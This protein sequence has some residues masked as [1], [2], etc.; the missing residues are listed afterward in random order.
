[1][2]DEYWN[3]FYEFEQQTIYHG[4][5][6]ILIFKFSFFFSFFVI[7]TIYLV[8][9]VL[10]MKYKREATGK[11]LIPNVEF[12]SSLPGLV[13]VSKKCIKV[14]MFRGSTPSSELRKS[15]MTPSF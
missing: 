11:E 10:F 12:W 6:E 5:I 1:M 7:A 3:I 14:Y 13:K 4:H 2:V 15:Q 8:A 9:G